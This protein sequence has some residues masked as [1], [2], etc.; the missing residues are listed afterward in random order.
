VFASLLDLAAAVQAQARFRFRQ[1]HARV[2]PDGVG[3]GAR[4][5]RVF[6]QGLQFAQARAHFKAFRAQWSHAAR[7]F[8]EL[9]LARRQFLGRVDTRDTGF[10][11]ADFGGEPDTLRLAYSFVSPDE[12]AEGVARLAAALPAAV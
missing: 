3:T 6:R 7:R 9:G 4:N 10:Q 11:G 12:I 5:G 8:L 1:R 2:L